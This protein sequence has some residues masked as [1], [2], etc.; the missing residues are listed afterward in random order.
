MLHQSFLVVKIVTLVLGHLVILAESQISF[1]VHL[2]FPLSSIE[3]KS[4]GIM[5][6]AQE[7]KEKE[8][9]KDIQGAPGVIRATYQAGVPQSIYEENVN[10]IS[11]VR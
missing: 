4:K 1:S 3:E 9:V 2:S 6:F 7:I 11:M 10:K 5:I 8:Y